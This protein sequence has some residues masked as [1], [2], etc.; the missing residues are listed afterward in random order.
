MDFRFIM[1]VASLQG[2]V[3]DNTATHEYLAQTESPLK[4]VVVKMGLVSEGDSKGAIIGKICSDSRWGLRED[5][6]FL[7]FDFLM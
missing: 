4:I 6:L 5:I 1:W 3:Y 7:E 2:A